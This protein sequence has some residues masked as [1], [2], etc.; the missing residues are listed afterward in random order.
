MPL[1]KT[2]ILKRNILIPI[3]L[4]F[5]IQNVY[6]DNN[7]EISLLTCSS[8]QESYESWGHSAIR[9]I[10]YDKF[11]DVT[12]NFGIFDF[13]TP[14]FYLKFIQ[15]KLKYQLGIDN[16]NAFID[17]YISEGRQVVEQKLNL[18]DECE[19]R[20]IEKL[21]NLYKPE[22]RFYYYN[23]VGKNCTTELRDL[24]FSNVN[25]DLNNKPTGKTAR[26]LISEYLTEEHW[27]KF[28]MNLIMGPK[29]DRRI[30]IYN[31]MFLPDYLANELRKVK[32]NGKSLVLNEKIYNLKMTSDKKQPF[33][34]DPTFIFSLLAFV[35]LFYK[36]SNLQGAIFIL[37]GILGLLV[38]SISVFSQHPELKNNFN[39]L[40]CNP[41]YLISA[42]FLLTKSYIK[43]QM[44]LSFLLL[45]LILATIVVWIWDLQHYEKGFLP[46]ALILTIYNLRIVKNGYSKGYYKWRVLDRNIRKGFAECKIKIL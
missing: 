44:Y 11:Y 34:L 4:I 20:I 33:L 32:V 46:I 36:S 28:G 5:G 21:E 1:L 15:G 7:I 42:I 6:P 38:L 12:Y 18:S 22:N 3:L 30:D 27:T 45:S 24:I 37:V 14:N 9:V 43:L 8:G 19:K 17:S 10:D 29:V 2:T 39:L 31:S 35:V 13:N 23:F 40:W 16:T 41:L 26:I 25:T